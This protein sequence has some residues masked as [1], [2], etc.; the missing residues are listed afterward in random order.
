[1]SDQAVEILVVGALNIQITTAD[2]VDSL[3][4]DH[5]A[6]VGVL[7]SGVCSK[8]G[9]VRL[10]HR[11]G[12]LRRRVDAKLQLA[13]LAV[14]DRQT[15]HEQ[16]SES[17]PGTTAERVEH[18]ETLEAGA[19]VGNAADLVENIINQLFSDCVVAT[20]VV[21]G[22]IFLSSNHVL[23]VEKGTVG[24]GADLVHDIGL[25]IAVDG[26]R[27]EFAVSYDIVRLLIVVIGNETTLPVSEKKVL[28]P[29]SGSDS[30]RS[31]V[32]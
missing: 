18:Q 26:A 20:S 5:E 1:M 31:S 32:K 7:E 29:S 4:I 30:L 6:A 13:L 23:R 11:G 19:V 22:G 25:E 2:V 8:N 3:V 28:K 24:A 9:V 14:V 27:D 10:D 21:V 17:R 15:L 16:G 12:D